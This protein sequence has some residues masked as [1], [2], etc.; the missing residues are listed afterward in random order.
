[1]ESRDAMVLLR[2]CLEV[3]ISFLTALVALF[4]AYV[5]KFCFWLGL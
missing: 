5:A 3:V 4:A 2:V 1:M